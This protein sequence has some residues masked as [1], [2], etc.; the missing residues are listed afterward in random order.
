MRKLVAIGA[1][2]VSAVVFAACGQT[3]GQNKAQDAY[4]REQN[5]VSTGLQR[6]QKSQQLPTFDWSQVRQTLID[7]ET[8]Q[9]KGVT[10]TSVGYSDYGTMIWWCPS[11]GSPVASTTE[12]TPTQQYV[13][14]PNDGDR[15][16]F[17]VD[18]AEPTGVYPGQSNG[19]WVICTDDA[20]QKIG[21]YWEGPVDTT[22]GVRGGLPADKRVTVDEATFK[23]SE[24]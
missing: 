11:I 12:L 19:T 6:M 17:P 5:A 3:E 23:F 20:G 8:I 10:T 13:D 14:I 16:K 7:V 18:Q 24:K 4:N 22:V 15:Q 1:V 21:K 2:L 9:A